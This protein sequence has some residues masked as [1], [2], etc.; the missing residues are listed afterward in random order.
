MNS[1]IRM[2]P[3]ELRGQANRLA[4]LSCRMQDVS[5]KAKATMQSM[6][7]SVTPDFA[8]NLDWKGNMLASKLDVLANGLQYGGTRATFAANA[9]EAADKNVA[10]DNCSTL[11][12]LSADNIDERGEGFMHNVIGNVLDE[13]LGEETGAGLTYKFFLD[14]AKGELDADTL[15]NVVD[16][17][18]GSDYSTR[19]IF[20][21]G[22][23]VWDHIGDYI[24][25]N[26]EYITDWQNG[27]YIDSISRTIGS[28]SSMFALMYVD[29][30][31]STVLGFA[32]SVKVWPGVTIGDVSELLLGDSFSGMWDNGIE[33]VRE[34]SQDVI[35]RGGEIMQDC[36]DTTIN[37]AKDTIDNIGDGV[38]DI[39][40]GIGN[41]FGL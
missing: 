20:E 14:I 21:A 17:L 27:D 36:F 13:V 18:A 34:F 29:A 6:T 8:C 28:A 24:S 41:F 33:N 32:D 4:M 40:K 37:V 15:F 2:S 35:D 10:N 1:E 11:E 22:E 23:S 26:E 30:V 39:C 38:N 3:E 7:A 12:R 16:G 25:F 31:G 5:N 19:F 9:L